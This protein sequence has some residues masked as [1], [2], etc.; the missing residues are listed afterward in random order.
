MTAILVAI[1]GA[2]GALA[3]YGVAHA[4][5]SS[6]F[7]WATLLVNVTGSFLLGVVLR[8]TATW[9][10]AVSWRA[11]LAVGFCGAFTTFSTFS[12]ESLRLLQDRHWGAGLFNIGANTLLCLAA[13]AAGMLIAAPLQR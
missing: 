13:V 12:Y 8:A 7:P 5:Y 1:G 6:R 4:L 2:L 11:F 10:A 3:R 9:P